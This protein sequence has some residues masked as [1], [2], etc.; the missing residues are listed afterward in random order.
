[1]IDY[2]LQLVEVLLELRPDLQFIVMC[3]FLVPSV[4]IS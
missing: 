2:L 3:P 4:T 1:V